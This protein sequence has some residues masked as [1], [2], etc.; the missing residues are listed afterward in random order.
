MKKKLILKNSY[1]R[2]SYKSMKDTGNI[3]VDSVLHKLRK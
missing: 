3:N 1:K 2:L